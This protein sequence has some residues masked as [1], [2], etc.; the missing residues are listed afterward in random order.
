M[1]KNEYLILSIKKEKRVIFELK[2]K[3]SNFNNLDKYLKPSQHGRMGGNFHELDSYISFLEN[4]KFIVF[5]EIYNKCKRVHNLYLKNLNG[6]G[7]SSD[8]HNI[9][10]TRNSVATYMDNYLLKL[11]TLIS[12]LESEE[13]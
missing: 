6:Y 11:D 12:D 1:N 13:D 7:H 3:V 8:K 4:L 9:I 5:E 10:S 2:S